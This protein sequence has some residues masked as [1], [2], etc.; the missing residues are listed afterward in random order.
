[1]GVISALKQVALVEEE[2]ERGEVDTV[3]PLLPH[4]HPKVLQTNLVN[5]HSKSEKDGRVYFCNK[6]K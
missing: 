3:P 1:M 6:C 2:V 5:I 4:H